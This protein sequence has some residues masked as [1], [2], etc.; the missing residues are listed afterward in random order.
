MNHD[1]SSMTGAWWC[2]PKYW[3][4]NTLGI[5]LCVGVP[6]IA[7]SCYYSA[8]HEVGPCCL[9]RWYTRLLLLC[10]IFA[11]DDHFTTHF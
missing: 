8:K 3:R 6:V 5:T 1:D 2:D 11:D 4:Q 7:L 10:S 9:C